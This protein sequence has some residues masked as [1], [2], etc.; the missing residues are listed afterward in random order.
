LPPLAAQALAPPEIDDARFTTY[1]QI[2]WEDFLDRSSGDPRQ[3]ANKLRRPE[4]VGGGFTSVTAWLLS[5]V[6]IDEVDIVARPV[7]GASDRG[8]W[9]A[10]PRRYRVY[11]LMDKQASGFLPGAQNAS[12]LEHEQGHF[13]LA[14]LCARRFRIE[15]GELEATGKSAEQAQQRLIRLLSEQ[16]QRLGRRFRLIQK[17]YD[18]ETDHAQKTRA[19]ARWRRDLDRWLQREDPRVCTG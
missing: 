13:D 14:E 7:E 8:R 19:Q 18:G 6:Q 17:R 1:R 15:V 2:T 10:V 5:V 11:S 16:H 9:V 4:K 3:P 12:T